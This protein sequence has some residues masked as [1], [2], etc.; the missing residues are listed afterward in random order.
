MANRVFGIGLNKTGTTSLGKALEVLG[1]NQHASCN[2]EMVRHWHKGEIDKIL[3]FAKDYNSFED[4]PWPL[5]YKELFEEFEDAKFILSKRSSKEVWFESLCKHSLV[6]G[7]TEFR[8]LIYGSYMPHDFKEEHF[9]IY[10]EH[11]QSVLDFFKKNAP[12][13]IKVI[14]WENGDSWEELC[15]FLGKDI[16]KEEFPFLN[17]N[18]AFDT[19]TEP[20][21]ISINQRIKNKVKRIIG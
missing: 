9:R 5:I 6:T 14:C 19:I 16:P 17:K 21:K 13:K 18:T 10:E 11:N 1:Y 8:K 20:K 2:L 4:W 7:P 15:A 12:E 3:E